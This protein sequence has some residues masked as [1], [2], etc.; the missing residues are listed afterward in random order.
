VPAFGKTFS[1]YIQFQKPILVLILVVGLARL[2]LSLAGVPNSTVKWLSL[3]VVALLGAL[4]YAIRVHTS[5][6]GSYQHLLPLLVIQNALA[7]IISAAAIAIAIFSGKDNI[8]SAPEYSG[9][10][11]GKTWTHAG[12]HLVLGIIVGSLLLWLVTSLILFITKKLAPAS[13]V[14]ATA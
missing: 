13:R 2:S 5:G 14:R 1:E 12:A 9:G 7:N 11:D 8:F 6:F 4:Y 10:G 3:T